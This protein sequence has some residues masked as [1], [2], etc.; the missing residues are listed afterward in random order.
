M[1]QWTMTAGSL[2]LPLDFSS[3][4]PVYLQVVQGLQSMIERQAISEGA[5]LPGERELAGQ[6]GVSRVTVRQA[7]RL[8]EEQGFITRRHGSGTY[9]APRRIVQPLSVLTGFSEDMRSRGLVPGGQVLRLER[10]RPSPQ[11]AMNLALGPAEEVVR[12]ERLRTANGEPLALETSTMPGYLLGPVDPQHMEN[13]SLYALLRARGFT[14]ARAMQR[15]SARAADPSSARALHVDE[16]AALLATERVTWDE[17][18]RVLEFAR[19]LYRGDR[20]DFIAEL[21]H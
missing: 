19:A 6:L 15:L 17:Q 12:L 16:G 9:V 13:T 5:A 3:A 4:T 7:L 20:Y 11:E 10:T 1:V 21:Q 8:L 18:G 14:P 2:S